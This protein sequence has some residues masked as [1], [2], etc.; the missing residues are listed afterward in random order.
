MMTNDSH[1]SD[2]NSGGG[3]DNLIIE[4]PSELRPEGL[5]DSEV[6]DGSSTSRV[7]DSATTY[8]R[9]P[10]AARFWWKK[11]TLASPSIGLANSTPDNAQLVEAV[12]D[13]LYDKDLYLFAADFYGQALVSGVEKEFVPSVRF[14]YRYLIALLAFVGPQGPVAHLNLCR[15][16]AWSLAQ[17]F[18]RQNDYTV[19]AGCFK[20]PDYYRMRVVYFTSFPAIYRVV[21]AWID[22]PAGRIAR[23][24]RHQW[25]KLHPLQPDNLNAAP[26][27]L[28][29][30]RTKSRT[31]SNA[32]R[33]RHPTSPIRNCQSWD[34]ARSRLYGKAPGT[35][36]TA[37]TR[38]HKKAPVRRELPTEPRSRGKAKTIPS[39]L[40]PAQQ[41]S[42][43]LTK[44]ASNNDTPPTH[45]N[46][47]FR[48]EQIKNP[49][50]NS[51]NVIQVRTLT[52]KSNEFKGRSPTKRFFSV[53]WVIVLLYYEDPTKERQ[54]SVHV[55]NESM[56]NQPVLRSSSTSL[57][58]IYPLQ[59][60][61]TEAFVSTCG[62]EPG[63]ADFDLN[64]VGKFARLA[65]YR[66]RVLTGKHIHISSLDHAN[67]KP[68][69]LQ[70]LERVVALVQS[71]E[72]RALVSGK[73]IVQ[74]DSIAHLSEVHTRVVLQITALY[75]QYT[76]DFGETSFT[77]RLRSLTRKLVEWRYSRI[78]EVIA[79]L[80]DAKT[81]ALLEEKQRNLEFYHVHERD[82]Q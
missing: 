69:W 23:W 74:G 7:I 77:R 11:A 40:V 14:R 48:G 66:A 24:W 31:N 34:H 30:A 26:P 49:I 10:A 35:S 44:A 82:Q 54:L 76:N 62:R 39:R 51:H 21:F 72:Q 70:D 12:A 78:S 75:R 19:H 63:F 33:K 60:P 16:V 4:D 73:V 57:L 18:R 22:G 32:R 29:N 47:Q 56:D 67:V 45:E 17:A 15:S 68:Q 13:R 27:L 8:A 36:P 80:D 20:D 55:E 28:S 53:G 5:D 58:D 3:I 25:T 2:T 9:S 81:I 71:Q 65:H 37:P 52:K 6:S 1:N 59:I 50:E 42:E 43:F 64:E 41:Q 46:Q 79:V 61:S 38:N